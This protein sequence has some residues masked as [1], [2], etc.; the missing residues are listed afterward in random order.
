V[1]LAEDQGREPDPASEAWKQWTS[2]LDATAAISLEDLLG[3]RGRSTLAADAPDSGE[4]EPGDD[5]PDGAV[6]QRV[7][8]E[9][10]ALGFCPSAEGAGP[11]A[12]RKRPEPQEGGGVPAAKR[13][14]TFTPDPGK[15]GLA[16]FHELCSRVGV[17]KRG[18]G[19]AEGAAQRWRDCEARLLDRAV[20][21]FKQCCVREAERQRCGATVSFDGLSRNIEEFPKRALRDATYYVSSWGDGVSADCWYH[22]THGTASTLKT[23]AS[24]PFSAVL[25]GMLPKFVDRLK[26]CGFT[27]CAPEKGT[28]KVCVTWK[29][30]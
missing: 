11:A 29:A 30:P 8:A 12:P 24:I 6:V 18:R 13:A 19:A 1:A 4:G 23:G 5:R 2:A 10:E 27:S 17:E 20:E 14:R 28:W 26:D 16:N 3:S 21:L 15:N 25:M 22:A 9:L 7:R